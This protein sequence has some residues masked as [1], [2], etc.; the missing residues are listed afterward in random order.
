MSITLVHDTSRTGELSPRHTAQTIGLCH[1]AV[2][3]AALAGT[4]VYAVGF[5]GGFPVPKNV[6]TGGGNWPATV[7]FIID[8]ELIGLF[9]LQH[10]A[11]TQSAF[12]KALHRLVSPVIAN[13]LYLLCSCMALALLIAA[14]QPLPAVVWQASDPRI[15][16][17]LQS[18][19][20]FGWMAVLYAAFLTNYVELF[21]LKQASLRVV[22]WTAAATN[23]APKLYRFVRHPLYLGF[24]LAFW[25]APTMTAGHFLLASAATLYA[26]FGIWREEREIAVRF[27]VSTSDGPAILRSR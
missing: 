12:K 3:R 8:I 21:R 7:A 10:I 14:W 9:A 15:A 20:L 19:S 26:C 17:A 4:F 18:L 24:A 27:A 16:S 1:S 6:N 25:S 5:V 22:G 23:E 11:M 13:S 2:A